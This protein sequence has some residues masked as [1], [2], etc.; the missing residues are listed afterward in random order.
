MTMYALS[1]RPSPARA[2]SAAHLDF[3]FQS[4]ENWKAE[5]L[6]FGTVKTRLWETL[7]GGHYDVQLTEAESR[8][9]KCWTDLNCPLWPD[10]LER[11]TR[12]MT[13]FGR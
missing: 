13:S 9:V 10:Y 12:P 11:S 8:A 2:T 7:K 5:P 6:S 4:G 1:C 3:G